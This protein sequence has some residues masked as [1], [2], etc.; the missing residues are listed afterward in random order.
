MNAGPSG[1]S[2]G[3]RR[4]R[5][6]EAMRVIVTKRATRKH[7]GVAAPQVGKKAVGWESKMYALR[8]IGA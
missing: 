6:R 3:Y 8:G 2:H 5:W 7:S 4:L 1:E